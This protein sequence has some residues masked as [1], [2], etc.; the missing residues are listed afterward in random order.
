MDKLNQVVDSRAPSSEVILR[1]FVEFSAD[2]LVEG[3][4]DCVFNR[5]SCGSD[6]RGWVTGGD[7]SSGL[8]RLLGFGESGLNGVRGRVVNV[9]TETL[10]PF[11]LDPV[12]QVLKLRQV[13]G[14][15]VRMCFFPT[16]PTLVC[17]LIPLN[18]LEMRP[19]LSL[20]LAVNFRSRPSRNHDSSW[21]IN[22]AARPDVIA[23]VNSISQLMV[24][25]STVG[26]L[27]VS[28]AQAIQC[29]LS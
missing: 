23:R 1:R 18:R 19:L 2:D 22:P 5:Y 3:F 20:S 28:S 7:A 24:T 26:S 12:V 14:S 29:Y 8:D 15:C 16:E 27:Q 13:F 17:P 21:F 11:V 9:E 4:V 6:V 10:A 25:G